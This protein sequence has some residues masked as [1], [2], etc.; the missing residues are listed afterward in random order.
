[1]WIF[2]SHST[3]KDDAAGRQR[4]LD[5]EVA[6]K[7]PAGAPSGHDVLLDFKRLEPSFKW[8]S[9]LDEWM[10]TCHAAVLLLTPKALE[11]Q[12]VLKEATILAH[13]A[14][15]DTRFLLFPALLDGLTREQ[16]TAKDSRFSPL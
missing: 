1:M 8:R 5:I 2:I 15:R 14:A 9:E 16:L 4:L 3:G 13:R 11:S 12:W 6:L 7:G 10:A